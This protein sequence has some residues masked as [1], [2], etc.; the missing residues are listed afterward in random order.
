MRSRGQVPLLEGEEK[1]IDLRIVTLSSL[2]IIFTSVFFIHYAFNN[3]I[4]ISEYCTVE[5]GD[6]CL[7][8]N[9]LLLF[10]FSFSFVISFI[11]VIETTIYFMFK[12]IELLTQMLEKRE[13]RMKGSIESLENRKSEIINAKKEAQKKYLNR[14][15]SQETYNKM[16]DRYE[17][18]LMEI[19]MKMSEMQKKYIKGW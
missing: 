14:R 1:M 17:S 19:E 6:M 15:I 9:L 10:I 5:G 18:E 11:M 2:L 16:K 4:T 7:P 3:F 8:G 12:G 13:K